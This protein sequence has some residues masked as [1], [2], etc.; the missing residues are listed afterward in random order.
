MPDRDFT[1]TPT[2]DLVVGGCRLHELLG[3]GGMGTVY[4][5]TQLALEREVAV[6]LVPSVDVD[7]S[8]IARFKR[9]V[10]TAA[11]LEHPHS[12]PIYAAGEQDGLLY[13]VMRLV[14][15]P[16]LGALL[17]NEGPLDP[18]RAVG[19]IEQVAGAL[20]AA[21]AAGLVH[22]DVKPANILVERHDEGER[23]YLSDFGLMRR[24]S[25]AT[26]ITRVGEWLGSV[27][28]VAPEQLEGRPV[29][30]RADV[31]ALA[32]VLYTALSGRT[33]F[34]AATPTDVALAHQSSPPPRLDGDPVAERLSAVIARGMAKHPDARY[35]SAGAL[36]AAARAALASGP[37]AAPAP[38]ALTPSQ[39]PALTTRPSG[40]T[41]GAPR[42][43]R[44]R[45][46]PGPLI[47]LV[48]LLLV[49]AGGAVAAVVALG[50]GS[51][52][53]PAPPPASATTNQ[54]L[55]APASTEGYPVLALAPF[56]VRYPPGWTPV[57]QERLVNGS[58]RRTRILSGDGAEM[59]LID[60]TPGLAQTPA[61][62]R[63]GVM[64]ATERQT[65]GYR[66]NLL[67]DATVAGRDAAVWEFTVV[68]SGAPARIDVFLNAGGSGYAVYGQGP[69]MDTIASI[70]LAVAQSLQ[71]R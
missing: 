60:R 54:Q 32:G 24:V 43:I 66:Q 53:R 55:P 11:A 15:G 51:A 69:T 70:T 20:D 49:G 27:D 21:H 57:E 26:A 5:A 16:D 39:P 23:A 3:R 62:A 34:P 19:L 48:L 68:G 59:L 6:K 12:I 31:Y 36:A 14:H 13:L 58:Y 30:L 1:P 47:A 4:R 44:P 8:L 9:E 45:R 17:I 28:Y 37:R 33:P 25:G 38:R 61:E 64:A 56:T 10:R 71:P 18:G 7:E 42:I 52:R 35:P 46:R 63:D 50:G 2:T 67:A 40:P 41:A 65:P 22:R 29:D